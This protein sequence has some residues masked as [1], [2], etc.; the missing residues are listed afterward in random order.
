MKDIKK[1]L[2]KDLREM[3]MKHKENIEKLDKDDEDYDKTSHITKNNS[4]K[5]KNEDQ[6]FSNDISREIN[7]LYYVDAS[8]NNLDLL[9]DN[10]YD[11]FDEKV[12]GVSLIKVNKL[13]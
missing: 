11:A 13:K 3:L 9:N 6:V 1:V 5:N 4:K 10:F 7:Y 12:E 8:E 2:K